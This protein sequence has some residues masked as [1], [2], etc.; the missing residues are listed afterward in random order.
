MKNL[1]TE[2]EWDF[3][4]SEVHI[5]RPTKS[6]KLKRELLFLLQLL[7]G[8]ADNE[9]IINIYLQTKEKYLSL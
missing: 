5:N 8:S 7:L 1:Q 9:F 2:V 3:I 6:N 4:I